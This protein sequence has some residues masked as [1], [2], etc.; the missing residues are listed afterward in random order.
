MLLS[1]CAEASVV[2]NDSSTTIMAMKTLLILRCVLIGLIL[3]FFTKLAFILLL[4]NKLS[5]VDKSILPNA[6]GWAGLVANMGT[7]Q[8]FN[9]CS[10]IIL[11]AK[12]LR[13]F[14]FT[15]ECLLVEYFL[16]GLCL[17]SRYI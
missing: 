2:L 7:D 12:I 17:P 5:Q 1:S 4:C 3:K 6:N 10:P 8:E 13:F 11:S 9:L 15:F 16:N 14:R